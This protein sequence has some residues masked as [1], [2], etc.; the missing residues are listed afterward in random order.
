MYKYLIVFNRFILR[1]N[2]QRAKVVSTI[3]LMILLPLSSLTYAGNTQAEAAVSLIASVTED[4]TTIVSAMED[5]TA[6][7]DADGLPNVYDP[8][9]DGDNVPD[10]EDAFSADPNESQDS[11]ADGVGDNADAFP[12]D[13]T[14]TV[15]TD[16]DGIGDNADTTPNGEGN[17]DGLMACFNQ[18]LVTAGTVINAA[19]SEVNLDVELEFSYEQ[20]IS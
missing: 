14:E 8:D 7:L 15:D 19:Y 5:L 13:E 4:A 9:D 2:Y 6:D 10:T 20:I 3:V 16:G 18:E 1:A 17:G 12:L 11:D